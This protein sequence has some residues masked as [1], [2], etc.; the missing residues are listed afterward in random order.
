[1]STNDTLTPWQVMFEQPPPAPINPD[2]LRAHFKTAYKLNDDQVEFIVRSASQSLRT[3]LASAERVL[4]SDNLCAEM[5]PV[6]H[7][8]KG[9]Y[10]NMGEDGWASIAR[11]MELAAKAGQLHDYAVVVQK[12]RQGGAVLVADFQCP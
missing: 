10:L 2:T 6:A 4:A 12:M 5:A 7:G 8:L 9:L 3:A 11:A 1:M